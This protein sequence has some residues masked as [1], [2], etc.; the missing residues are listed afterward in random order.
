M[1]LGVPIRVKAMIVENYMMTERW[2]E[3]IRLVKIEMERF[4]AFYSKDILPGLM[5]DISKIDEELEVIIGVQI[6]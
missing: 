3:E 5:E 4:L 6:R 2:K 1:Y